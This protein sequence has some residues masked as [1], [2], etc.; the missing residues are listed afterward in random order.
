MTHSEGLSK[1][2]F[3]LLRLIIRVLDKICLSD[4]NYNILYSNKINRNQ[5]KGFQICLDIY[6]IV[7]MEFSRMLIVTVYVIIYKQTIDD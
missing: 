4:H 2:K 3:L 6:H 5:R 7:P 1:E